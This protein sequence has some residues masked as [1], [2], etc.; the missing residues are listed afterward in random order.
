MDQRITKA[1]LF[2]FAVCAGLFSLTPVN[3]QQASLTFPQF[4]CG[5]GVEV[6]INLINPSS[7]IEK[8]SLLFFDNTGKMMPLFMSGG[9]H[10]SKVDFFISPG[11][12]WKRRISGSDEPEPKVGYALVMSENAA[13][14]LVGNLIYTVNGLFDL[15]VPDCRPTTSARVYVERHPDGNSGYA[16]LNRGD[17]TISVSLRVLD[18]RGLNI[19]ETMVTL[20]PGEKESGFLDFADAIEHFIGTLEATS[21]SPFYI[22]GLRQRPNGAVAALPASVSTGPIVGS[23]LLYFI[24]SGI[25]VTAGGYSEAELKSK[26]VYELTGRTK[27]ANPTA[28][29]IANN[30]RYQAITVHVFFLNDKSRDYLDFLLVLRCDESLTFDPFDFE[31]PGAGLKTSNLLFGYGLPGS[32]DVKPAADFG[33][34]RFVL[35]VM[36]V[37]AVDADSN[38]EPDILYPEEVA[39]IGV[40]GVTPRNTGK[41]SGF[42]AANLH[43]FNA[44][45]IVFDYLSGNQVYLPAGLEGTSF[46]ADDAL[47]T[48]SVFT[49]TRMP[50]SGVWNG[51]PVLVDPGNSDLFNYMKERKGPATGSVVLPSTAVITW[52]SMP[53]KFLPGGR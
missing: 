20:L 26:T 36:A 53:L 13:S 42:S 3:A 29:K 44:L 9:E 12:A 34:G 52:A 33:S 5:G 4:A 51:I 35:S 27:G 38:N 7:T 16:I 28:I 17:R 1:V 10:A 2:A 23:Q 48:M 45:P 15:S 25:D 47:K 50:A 49:R 24:D 19:G 22:L 21:D 46:S 43:V 39:M 30:N 31:I 6:E 37:G 40:C 11:G 41:A 8:G 18:S 32:A 14:S